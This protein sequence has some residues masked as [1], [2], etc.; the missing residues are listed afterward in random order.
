MSKPLRLLVVE[1]SEAEIAPLVRELRRHGYAPEAVRVD[2]AAAMRAALQRQAW[3]VVI[4]DHALPG[5]SSQ[6][7]WR[8]LQE[9]GLDLPFIIVSETTGEEAAVMA[10]K[11]G[12]HDYVLKN[13]LTRLGPA[14]ERELQEA[15]GRRH[16]KQV[17]FELK[18]L[19]SAVQQ[20]TNCVL[21]ADRNGVIEYVN[22]AFERTTGYAREEVIGKTPRL[23]KSGR[24]D[25]KYYET[26]W[27]T[28]LAG[29]TFFAEFVNRKKSGELY[30]TEQS[31]SA[32]RDPHGHITHFVSTGHDITARK[33]AEVAL[34]ENDHRLQVALSGINMAVFHQD[35]A[36]RYTWMSQPQ[37]GYRPDQVVGH[38]DAEL[39][40]PEAA[41]Q[42]TQ[43]KQ[44]VLA[45]GTRVREEVSVMADGATLIFD[46]VAEPLRDASGEI[47]GLTGATLDISERARTEAALKL[48]RALVDQS[49]DT[50]EVVDPET[51]RFL[52]V[53]EKGCLDLGYR[54]A[55]FL[56]LSVFDVDPTFDQS[57]FPGAVAELRQA[58]VLTWAGRH[59]RKDGSTFP[60]EVNLKYVRLDRD[61]VVAAVHDITARQRVEE[62]LRE[63][64]ERFRSAME[65]SAIGMA[66]VAPDG[67]FLDVNRSLCRIVGYAREE[68]LATSFQAITH[69]DDL[70]ADLDQVRR[71][72][73]R[74]SETYQME[75]RY[76][77]KNGDVVW[78]LL[79]VSLVW[80]SDGS[81]RYFISQIEDITARRRAE[82]ALRESEDRYRSL[83]EESPETIG[84]FLEDKLVFINAAGARQ[85][86]A[87]SK[88]ELLGR[89]S[90]QL[91][92]P[93]DR[94][95]AV[96]RVR[97]RRAGETGMYPAEVRYRRLDG[98]TLPME[99]IATPITF[100]GQ[101]AMQFIARDITERKQAEQHLRDSAAL[102]HSLVENLPQHVFRKDRAGRFTFGN[103]LFCQSL[104]K[105]LA[106]ILGQT[107]RDLFPAPLAAKYQQDDQRVVQTGQTFEGAEE[108]RQ[109]NGKPIIVHVI[110]TPLRDAAGQIIG[111]QGIAWDITEKKQLEAQT[112]RTQRLESIGTLA[113]G[114]AHDLNNALAPI[115]MATEL[116]R[117]E[118]PDTAARYLDLIQG[119]A[120]RG[121]AMVKQL[122]TFAKGAEGERLLL[123]PKHLLKEMEK[124]I[125]S[126]FPKNI[127]LQTSYAKN[128]WT[129]LGDATQLHQVL[130]N[131]CVNARD[132]M[133]EGGT[134]TLKAENLEI[135]TVY[136]QTVP[137]AK[138]GPYV[139]WHVTDTGTGIP[140]EI[141]ERIFD[142]FFTTKGP[143]KGTG[144]GLS[145]TLGLVKGHGGFIRVYSVPDQGT[146]FAVYLP[147][148]GSDASDTALLTKTE[149]TFR[150]H[151]E[152]ILVVDDEETVRNVLRAVLT[153]L[154][155]KVLTA[156]DGTA[157]LIQVAENQA[158]LRAVITD[159]HMPQMDGL[160]F[161][162]VL[163]GRLPQVGIIVVSGRLDEREADEFKQ[164]GVHALL[165][166]PFTQEKLVAALRTIFPK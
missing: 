13:H 120:Q 130:L 65:Y 83:V 26:L 142:P 17:Q 16:H 150:G 6:A 63:S 129:L 127:Q 47:I 39:L 46:L 82:E 75:K 30:H 54:R 89:K 34:R 96:D 59:R 98:T 24:H 99:V 71:I 113:G 123:Q 143:Q 70:N 135:D 78:V 5:F 146:T 38:T 119:S 100:D 81:P 105:P 109:A 125:R 25:P 67:R 23:L 79:S 115:L 128:L 3:D 107:D 41:R 64:E 44:R 116:L 138:P 91:I 76:R 29:E 43:I 160:S 159:L 87:K 66:L 62:A 151:G 140:P 42:V 35:R 155:F 15:E 20:T 48:F 152:T 121:A 111:V 58:G 156:A 77:H 112:L 52:D 8:V 19:S 31:I 114:V 124:L 80:R 1:D 162:R 72:L 18:K 51:G 104:G 74:E 49:N 141:L 12:A 153:A 55:E 134:L 137:E 10:M 164:L 7:A 2:A 27:R 40:P 84:I 53:N 14:V 32:I 126:T 4:A 95:A 118:F 73:E 69:P 28:I 33:Q 93:D 11:A 92:H 61:Y 60:V 147:A 139:V 50:I 106:E 94:P 166:K 145:T 165:D 88:E 57:A 163:K 133:P 101:A 45:T 22:P 148:F 103:G 97:R 136:A 9:S 154:N 86:G 132:A 36:L 108:H 149:M 85:L 68:L 161:V 122:L 157:A 131:L 117:L 37:L 158:D 21:M 144:L 102:Y 110:K 56:A 90:E